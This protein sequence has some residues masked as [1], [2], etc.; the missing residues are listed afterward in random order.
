MSVTGD[1]NLATNSD[2][3]GVDDR[4]G[5]ADLV[6]YANREGRGIPRVATS[7]HP[8]TTVDDC[9]GK[10]NNICLGERECCLGFTVC[11]SKKGISSTVRST[12][13]YTQI[14]P[15]PRGGHYPWQKASGFKGRIHH[16]VR[17]GWDA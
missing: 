14:I 7:P 16:G 11:G 4:D 10:N 8:A 9:A 13:N 5:S 12:S 1:S 2:V 17:L 3:A 15:S 6:I